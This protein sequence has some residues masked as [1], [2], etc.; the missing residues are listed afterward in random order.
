MLYKLFLEL[1]KYDIS[2]GKID[3]F[4]TSETKLGETFPAAQFSL[5]GLWK[6]NWFDRNQNGGGLFLE[7]I[8]PHDL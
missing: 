2:H 4:M 1:E 6:P 8:H 3:I 5:Q 7:M